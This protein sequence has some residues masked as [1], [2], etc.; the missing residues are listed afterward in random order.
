ME[1]KEQEWEEERKKKKK[2]ND[3]FISAKK[4][5]QKTHTSQ[6]SMGSNKCASSVG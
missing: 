5:G 4:A 6:C 2:Y 1:K 3:K